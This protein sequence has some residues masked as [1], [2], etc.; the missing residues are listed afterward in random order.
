MFWAIPYG[1]LFFS[2]KNDSEVNLFGTNVIFVHILST[3]IQRMGKLIYLVPND[4]FFGFEKT[5]GEVNLFGTAVT[6]FC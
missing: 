2:E 6:F 3:L 5:D 1:M 4:F